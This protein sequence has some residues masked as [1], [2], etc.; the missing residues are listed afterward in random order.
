MRCSVS[1]KVFFP[2]HFKSNIN[3]ATKSNVRSLAYFIESRN[4][5][6]GFSI[7]SVDFFKLSKRHPYQNMFVI[8]YLCNTK[9]QFSLDSFYFCYTK[10]F[11][12]LESKMNMF[13]L[14][15]CKAFH[16]DNF[17][18]SCVCSSIQRYHLYTLEILT[19]SGWY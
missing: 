11:P 14:L 13:R 2:S 3:K 18:C 7:S 5:I 15:S 17:H 4:I 9:Y 12:I 6:D 16:W 1:L 10:Y 19:E 8:H